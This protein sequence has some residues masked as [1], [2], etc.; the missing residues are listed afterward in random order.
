MQ[1]REVIFAT[2]TRIHQFWDWHWGRCC[3]WYF[4]FWRKAL[5]IMGLAIRI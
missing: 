4:R 2:N 1:Y 3:S 5:W